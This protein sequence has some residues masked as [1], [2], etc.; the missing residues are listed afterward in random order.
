MFGKLG[1][2]HFGLWLQLKNYLTPL[3]QYETDI[4]Y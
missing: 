3:G 2:S 1:S 4:F